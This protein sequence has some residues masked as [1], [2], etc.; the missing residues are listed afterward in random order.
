MMAL[1]ATFVIPAR[2]AVGKFGGMSPAVIYVF[3]YVIVPVVQKVHSRMGNDPKAW[4]KLQVLV[5]VCTC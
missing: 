2:D 3:D 5:A 1:I 4:A